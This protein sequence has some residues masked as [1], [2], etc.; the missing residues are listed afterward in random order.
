MSRR[1][2]RRRKLALDHIAL[3]I[4]DAQ[5]LR[6]Q[7]LERHPTRLDDHISVSGSRPLTLPLVIVT[8]PFAGSSLFIAQ[9]ILRSSGKSNS[10]AP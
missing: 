8:S 10:S 1:I 5:T 3:Q 9:T 6:R 4:D 2:D 7:V